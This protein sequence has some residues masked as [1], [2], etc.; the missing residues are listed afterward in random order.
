MK[1]IS[2]FSLLVALV[3]AAAGVARADTAELFDK[4]CATCHGKDGKAETAMGR[5]LNMRNLSDPKVQASATD[6][7]W[8]RVIVE[9]VKGAGGK[10]VMPATKLTDAEVKELVKLVRGFKKP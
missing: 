7:Q 9:G 2:G 5:K 10:N 3:I 6:A 8:E 1:T 4:K